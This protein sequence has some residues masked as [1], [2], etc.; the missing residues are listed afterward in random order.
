MTTMTELLSNAQI[1]SDRV[2]A[3]ADKVLPDTVITYCQSINQ[4]V[5]SSSKSANTRFGIPATLIAFHH[6][7]KHLWAWAWER[8]DGQNALP[9]KRFG[10]K[11][12]VPE[13]ATPRLTL[14][15]HPDETPKVNR[16]DRTDTGHLSKCDDGSYLSRFTSEELMALSHRVFRAVSTHVVTMPDDPNKWIVCTTSTQH[17]DAKW[18]G[19]NARKALDFYCC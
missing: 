4:L 19:V 3:K 15:K 14:P 6:P 9:V 8:P 17:H 12:Q 18:L 7:Y 13:F 1:A 10:L 11:R 5:F 2:M 16:F